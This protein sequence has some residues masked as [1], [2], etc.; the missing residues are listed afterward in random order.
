MTPLSAG[1]YPETLDR[2]LAARLLRRAAGFVAIEERDGLVGLDVTQAVARLIGGAQAGPR[3]QEIHDLEEVSADRG[4]LNG[5]RAWQLARLVESP[6]PFREMVTLFWLDLFAVSALRVD[7]LRLYHDLRSGLRERAFDSLEKVFAFALTHPALLLNLRAPSNY[8]SQPQQQIG[9]FVVQYVVGHDP[10]EKAALVADIA[11]AYTGMFVTS[12]RL[13]VLDYEHDPGEKTVGDQTGDLRAEDVARALARDQATIENVVRRLFGWFVTTEVAIPQQLLATA[14]NVAL[15]GRPIAEVLTVLLGWEECL[16]DPRYRR[17][18]SPLEV[19]LAV[20]RPFGYRA[21]THAAEA[22]AE[23]GWDV[24]HPPTLAG[25]PRGQAWLTASQV[26]RHLA[27]VRT[28]LSGGENWGAT[29]QITE[30]LS[31]PDWSSRLVET[32]LDGALSAEARADWQ[33]LAENA[34]DETA[35]KEAVAF[36]ASLPEFQL[37]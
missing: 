13:R 15:D 28:M 20:A 2:E 19:Y 21:T 6:Q 4:Q 10:G 25:W 33:K 35:K 5:Y 1:V 16:K 31:R 11:R 29:S 24:V 23:L 30:A 27:L 37:A 3:W 36:L 26:A 32:L 9:R 12:G 34:R 7:A 17:V 18:K 22:L 8:R 14:K